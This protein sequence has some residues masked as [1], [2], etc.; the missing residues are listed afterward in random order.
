MES[1]FFDGVFCMGAPTERLEFAMLNSQGTGMVQSSIAADGGVVVPGTTRHYQSWHRDTGGVS[2]C[3]TG[4]N[5][6][7]GVRVDWLEPGRPRK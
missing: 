2:P 6:T 4:A 1:T 7:N 3:G 5:L